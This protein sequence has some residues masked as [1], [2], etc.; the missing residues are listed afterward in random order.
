MNTK[1]Q[2]A[3]Q[4][5]LRA[6]RESSRLSVM[7]RFAIASRAGLTVTDAECLDFLM[8]TG[9]ATAGELARQTNLTT[10]AITGMIRRLEKAGYIR[11]ERDLADK[12]RVIVTLVPH[13]LEQGKALYAAFQKDAEKAIADYS[14]DQLAFL[15]EHY[16]RMS[17]VYLNQLGKLRTDAR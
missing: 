5:Y 8:D 13:R 6:G 10:G 12:R 7:F 3:L 11:S 15:A 17:A 9:S 16:K 1:H 2:R 4:A 14:T